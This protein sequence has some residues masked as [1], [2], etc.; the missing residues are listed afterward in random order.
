MDVPE[1]EEEEPGRGMGKKR[2][3]KSTEKKKKKKRKEKRTEKRTIKQKV[4]PL[5]ALLKI[6]LSHFT[7]YS[8]IL[9]TTRVIDLSNCYYCVL[10]TFTY[11]WFCFQIE[12]RRYGR[13]L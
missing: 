12:K 8:F 10:M 1:E 4:C 5:V 3:E 9:E 11:S 6:G 13:D 7:D 2:K